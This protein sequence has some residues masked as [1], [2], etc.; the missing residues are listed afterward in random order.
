[1]NKNNS[2]VNNG[3][4]SKNINIIDNAKQVAE[5]IKTIFQ[6]LNN[7]NNKVIINYEPEYNKFFKIVM[8]NKAPKKQQD[9]QVFL[10]NIIFLI[11]LSMD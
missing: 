7:K 6:K 11:Y 5:S 1:M 3:I 10:K 4:I 8:P 2:L 9:S